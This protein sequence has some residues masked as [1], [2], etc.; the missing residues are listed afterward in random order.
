VA[1]RTPSMLGRRGNSF[2]AKGE[3]GAISR[4]PS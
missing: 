3:T 4:S 2:G 1:K